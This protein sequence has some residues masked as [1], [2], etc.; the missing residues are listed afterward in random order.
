MSPPRRASNEGSS[1]ALHEHRGLT[2]PSRSL[3]VFQRFDTL[4]DEGDTTGFIGDPLDQRE[5]SLVLGEGPL[6]IRGLDG[7]GQI[8]AGNG[9]VGTERDG[10]FE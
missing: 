7:F 5:V 9:I 6:G 2:R 10:F 1:L 3:L 8:V 4:L